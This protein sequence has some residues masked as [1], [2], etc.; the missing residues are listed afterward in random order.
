[1][2]KMYR[3]NVETFQVVLEKKVKSEKKD[4]KMYKL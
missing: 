3:C 4:L 2:Y 1:M